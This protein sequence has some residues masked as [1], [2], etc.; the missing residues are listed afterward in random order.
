MANWTAVL[1]DARPDSSG[2][3]NNI[4]LTVT[5]TNSVT[6]DVQVRS[7]FGDSVT[8]NSLKTWAAAQ[9]ASLN[10]RDATLAT[11]QTAIQA[12]TVLATG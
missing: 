1:T 6:Q 3:N 11:A 12:Q 4:I 8:A 9:I 10:S 5:F 7:T 2:L